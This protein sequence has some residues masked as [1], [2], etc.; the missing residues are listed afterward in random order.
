MKSCLRDIW[1]NARFGFSA[2]FS[3]I[4]ASKEM[5]RYTECQNRVRRGLQE[6]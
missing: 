6:I 2:D 1:D 5:R 3:D 4:S